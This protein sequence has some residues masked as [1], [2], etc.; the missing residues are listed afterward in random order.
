MGWNVIQ[1]P[2]INPLLS[3][4]A[5]EQRFYFVHSYYVA[6]TN[7]D[8]VKRDWRK[9]PMLYESR[10]GRGKKQDWLQFA[11]N[12]VVEVHYSCCTTRTGLF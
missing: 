2:R 9:K 11:C 12:A 3:S 8:D 10:A 4:D 6:C 1:V 5:D 7:P